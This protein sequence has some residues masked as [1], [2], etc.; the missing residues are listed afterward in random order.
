M[1]AAAEQI[2]PESS[3][4]YIPESLVNLVLKIA[5]EFEI[6]GFNLFSILDTLQFALEMNY[7]AQLSSQNPWD[8]TEMTILIINIIRLAEKYNKM[9]SKLTKVPITKMYAALDIDPNKINEKEFQHFKS[10]NFEIKSPVIVETIYKLI[11]EHMNGISISKDK[12]MVFSLDVLKIFYCWRIKIYEIVKTV[13][14]N[15]A[16]E[17][18]ADVKLVALS[19]VLAVLKLLNI[20]ERTTS[21]V[22]DAMCAQLE[23]GFAAKEVNYLSG[24]IFGLIKK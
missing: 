10:F 16:K 21:C 19:V 7:Q 18:L 3:Q 5:K 14:Q 17:L 8:E 4:F 1:S 6:S 24:V 20:S 13:N 11:D 15:Q 12:V 22:F 23:N 9:T 2:P